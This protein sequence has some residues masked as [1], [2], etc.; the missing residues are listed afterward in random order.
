METRPIAKSTSPNNGRSRSESR[1]PQQHLRRRGFSLV[2]LMVVVVILGLLA[3]V[4]TVS[5]TDYLVKGKQTTARN[6]IALMKNALE[7]YYMEA[8]RYPSNDQG[9][10]L[11]KEKTPK[12]PNG[13]LQGDLM[14]PWSNQYLYVY[15]G[16]HGTYDIVS[17]GADGQEGGEGADMDI[18]SWDLAGEGV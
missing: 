4:V 13:I 16:L 6:E 11:L 17:L 5:V 7:L 9:L 1:A 12:H 10:A 8:N 18:V 3:T 15:P 2:E 14:D